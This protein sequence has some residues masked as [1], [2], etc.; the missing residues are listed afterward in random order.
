MR[1]RD[2]LAG[3]MDAVWYEHKRA[4]WEFFLVG[5]YFPAVMSFLRKF[6]SEHLTQMKFSLSK[7]SAI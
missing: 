3:A 7:F 4:L 6:N 1:G 5:L 2:C